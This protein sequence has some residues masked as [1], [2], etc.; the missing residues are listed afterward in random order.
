MDLRK[1]KA[2]QAYIIG[3]AL[4]DGNLSNPNGRAVR[5][6][7]TCDVKYKLI[8]EEIVVGLEK[9]FP[10]NKVSIVRRAKTFCDISL[11][12]NELLRILP[13]Q[14]GKGSKLAQKAR[15]PHWIFL[16]KE[17]IRSCLRG[18]YQT[19][20]SVY[21]DRNY[22]M[23][24]FTNYTKELA[25]DVYM[26]TKALGFSPTVSRTKTEK[27]NT[28]YTVRLARNTESFLIVLKLEKK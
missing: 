17:Y 9:L 25:E 6:R 22:L 2:L 7:V 23:A 16:R 19:D 10:D 21:R 24:N 12:S 14:V 3:V 13:W 5:L 26:M 8:R 15:V 1:H 20:G 27:G 11:Y 4:G 18:L 28:K